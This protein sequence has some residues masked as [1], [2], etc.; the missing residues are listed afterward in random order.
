MRDQYS[1]LDICKALKIGREKLRD[2]MN[3]NYIQP[4]IQEARGQGTKALFSRND[5]Y[6]IALF[7]KFIADK[8]KRDMAKRMSILVDDKHLIDNSFIIFQFS[9]D[10]KDKFKTSNEN[11]L[12]AVAGDMWIKKIDK[13]MKHHKYRGIETDHIFIVNFNRIKRN[14]D[15]ALSGL[16]E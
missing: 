10:I 1:T 4:S 13:L 16:D 14:V 8:F 12:F 3:R 5:I 7:K 11:D 9:K 15:A 2:W 6:R